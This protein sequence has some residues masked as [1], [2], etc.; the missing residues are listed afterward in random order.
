VEE[1]R[2]GWVKKEILERVE[3]GETEI[4]SKMI[5]ENIENCYPFF[6]ETAEK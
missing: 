4:M 1:K 6:S 5:R 3:Q 2:K